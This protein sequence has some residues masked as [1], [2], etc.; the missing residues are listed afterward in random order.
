MKA[1][2]KRRNKMIT[3]VKT[4]DYDFIEETFG[5]DGYRY[6]TS[7]VKELCNEIIEDITYSRSFIFFKCYSGKTYLLSHSQDCCEQV[8]I[9]D[10][11]GFLEDLTG[12]LI[13]QAEMVTNTI[14]PEGYN[15]EHDEAYLWT[16]YKF[17]T[18]KGYVTIRWLGESNGYYSV[19]VDFTEVIKKEK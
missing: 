12:A 4:S 3:E 7:N 13:L 15:R 19:G 10:I 11:C 9:E 8:L 5:E 17:A 2:Q 1:K 14:D 16:F 18:I 6:L